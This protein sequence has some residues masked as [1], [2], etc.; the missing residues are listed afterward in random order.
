M[1]ELD[2]ELKGT[3]LQNLIAF[4][5]T[6]LII[7]KAVNNVNKKGHFQFPKLM[8]K[9]DIRFAYYYFDALKGYID[10]KNIPDAC[11]LS[12]WQWE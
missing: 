6:Y 7:T 5:N 1:E 9:L 3:N 11:S 2:K 4:N 10:D 12:T 8:E